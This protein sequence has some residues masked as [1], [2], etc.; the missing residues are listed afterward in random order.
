MGQVIV[1][2]KVMPADGDVD[3]SKVESE[4]KQKISPQRISREPVAFGIVSLM[5]TKLVDEVEG[6]ME[7]TEQAIRSV[8]GVGEV[9]VIEINRSM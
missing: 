4:I 2:F 5:V 6:A 8:N 3:I 7:N 1:T 9:E